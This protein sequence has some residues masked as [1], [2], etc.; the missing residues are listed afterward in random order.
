MSDLPCAITAGRQRA[1]LVVRRHILQYGASGGTYNEQ[2]QT[3]PRSHSQRPEITESHFFL[4]FQSRER[5]YRTQVV[6]FECPCGSLPLRIGILFIRSRVHP[7]T[8]P[9]TRR[10]LRLSLVSLLAF[11]INLRIIKACAATAGQ[12]LPP[13]VTQTRDAAVGAASAAAAAA[14]A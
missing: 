14:V 1:V 4:I 3:W 6:G 13:S 7:L 10:L 5:G 2:N 11:E 8:G 12:S 9:L